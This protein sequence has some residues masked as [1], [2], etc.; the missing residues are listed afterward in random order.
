MS[1]PT[2]GID[3]GATG[4][5]KWYVIPNDY[6]EKKIVFGPF[7]YQSA[8]LT[9]AA[10]NCKSTQDFQSAGLEGIAAD[11]LPLLSIKPNFGL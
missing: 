3:E 9:A 7:L 10:S 11:K 5:P 8:Y 2:L 4:F 6:K 1:D